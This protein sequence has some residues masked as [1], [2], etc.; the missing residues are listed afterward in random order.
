MPDRRLFDAP[1]E[2]PDEDLLE[3]SS[4]ARRLAEFI[5]SVNPPFTIGVYGEWGSGKTSFVHLVQYFLAHSPS[6]GEAPLFLRFSAWPHKTAE[7]LWRG[8]L[9]AIA[10]KLYDVVEPSFEP[11]P[12]EPPPESEELGPRLRRLLLGD[13]LVLG[14]ETPP[15]DPLA[16]YHSL[17]ARLDQT[18][19]SLGTGA[20]RPFHLDHEEALAVIARAAFATLGTLSPALAGLRGFFGL[21]TGVDASRL[22]RQERNQA[23]RERIE[24]V[25]QFRQMFKKLFR[26]KAAGRR[27]CVFIDDLD[28][29]MPD[30][31]L[32]LLEAIL[33]FLF[34]DEVPCI[35]LVA[36]DENLIGQGLRLRFREILEVDTASETREYFLRKGREYFEKIIQLPIRVPPQT[37]EQTHRFIAAQFPKWLAASDILQTA[38][39]DN[40][41]R[42]KQ[43]CNLLSY[44]YSVARPEEGSGIV[45]LLDK[46]L[47]LHAWSP[48]GWAYLDQ[49]ACLPATYQETLAR[50]ESCLRDSQ[51][52]NPAPDARERLHD[53]NEWALFELAV[54]LAPLFRLFQES[55]LFSDQTADEVA[56]LASFADVA[57]H[58]KT[59]LRTRDACFLR[60]LEVA[61]RR[62]PPGP[63]QFLQEGFTRLAEINHA[64]STLLSLLEEA[65]RGDG[66]SAGMATLEA[67]LEARRLSPENGTA[68]PDSHRA[69]LDHTR[70]AASSDEGND[71]LRRLLLERP[72]MSALLAYEI[73]AFAAVRPEIPPAEELFSHAVAPNPSELQK[74]QS[75]ARWALDHLPESSRKAAERGLGLRIDAA[76]HLVDLRVFAKLDAFNHCWPELAQRLRDAPLT[77]I[78]LETQVLQPESLSPELEPWWNK[79]CHDDQL[80][81]FLKLRPLFQ[82]IDPTVLR[83]YLKIAETAEAQPKSATERPAPEIEA[84]IAEATEEVPSYENVLI[85]FHAK[86]EVPSENLDLFLK[87]HYGSA[88]ELTH[89]AVPRAEA[90]EFTSRLS[91]FVR[92]GGGPTLRDMQ[93]SHVDTNFPELAGEIGD[94]LFARLFTGPV[95]ELLQTL[96]NQPRR[97]RFLWDVSTPGVMELPLEC[98]RFP[99]PLQSFP[100]LTRRY[101]IVRH[102]S[103]GT[104]LLPFGKIAPPLRI[105]AM[106]PGPG[107]L[108]PLNVAG[109]WQILRESLAP[110]EAAG[111]ALVQVLSRGNATHETLREALRTFRPH[112]FHFVGHGVIQDGQA[113]VLL[114]N[115][116]GRAFPISATVLTEILRDSP[117]RLAV[118]NACDTGTSPL[119]DAISGLAGALLAGGLPAVIGTLRQVTDE[120]ALVFTRE[121]YR[122]LTA[123][124]P[125]EAAIIEARKALNIEGWDWSVYAL[126]S[127]L[128]DLNFL[129]LVFPAALKI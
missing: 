113:S 26:D 56:A 77:L 81:A 68:L 18:P 79:I 30:V 99:P 61:A 74:A 127:R 31:A 9:L 106:F 126:F 95:H 111:A 44:K 128:E 37:A 76:R 121:F 13:A 47:A 71:A 29:T 14:A 60:V 55:P 65:A 101:S 118:L 102:L 93:V 7:E 90:Q 51:E 22:M 28:R 25:D 58:P 107:D 123:G 125:V 117:I 17:V 104:P 4:Y 80:L 23:L 52:D 27:V 88:E 10:R 97:L 78:R 11:A 114:E 15:P 110:A 84:T 33:V 87:I 82:A 66:W 62:S 98:L 64:D 54:T 40:P 6:S 103:T 85:L 86:Q 116:D 1:L 21:D 49:Q 73:A 12:G 5:R 119:N 3:T 69:I 48:V 32:D 20:H 63:E 92:A 36:A 108:S 89:V 24:S 100:A 45:A 46:I 19:G 53:E 39:G 8:L 42:L 96:L 70:N 34:D 94:R 16:G 72:R 35:F 2:N 43:Y 112:I 41:R 109:E 38:I 120:A 115:S 67:L 59:I 75:I 50:I 129:R 91:Q 122:S 124:Y 105:L 57:P 83:K